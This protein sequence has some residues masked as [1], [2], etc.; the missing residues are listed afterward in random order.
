[1]LHK[2]THRDYSY[3]QSVDEFPWECSLNAGASGWQHQWTWEYDLV[4]KSYC[5]VLKHL[6]EV[7]RGLFSSWIQTPDIWVLVWRGL[8]HVP[9][10]PL[11]DFFRAYNSPIPH[12][13][14][15]I[16]QDQWSYS[17]FKNILRSMGRNILCEEVVLYWSHSTRVSWG[18]GHS[19]D[20]DKEG[21]WSGATQ[22]WK[23]NYNL[24]KWK[25]L[26]PHSL[27]HQSLFTTWK[28]LHLLSHIGF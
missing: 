18:N 2:C 27:Q 13:P 12:L 14:F 8:D 16:K 19:P 4:T 15:P 7:G 17:P 10:C 22:S 11:P 1:M 28:C 20:G 3:H 9:I 6:M 26:L 5:S 23:F 24:Q 21:S 25:H